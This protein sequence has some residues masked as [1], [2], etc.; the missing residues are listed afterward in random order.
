MLKQRPQSG[1]ACFC[2]NKVSAD[3]LSIV[4]SSVTYTDTYMILFHF[5]ASLSQLHRTESIGVER[6][7][8]AT[9]CTREPTSAQTS[10]STITTVA[11][12]VRSKQTLTSQLHQGL[13]R[14][15]EH[16][17]EVKTCFLHHE[18]EFV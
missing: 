17:Q 13:E 14:Y 11:R 15:R 5:S 16:W 6:K 18:S 4:F 8:N 2:N 7:S 9:K 10:L 3:P 12:D 1:I